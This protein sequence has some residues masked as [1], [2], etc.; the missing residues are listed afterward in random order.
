MSEAASR[1]NSPADGAASIAGV[2]FRVAVA[3]ALVAFAVPLCRRSIVL[4]DEGYMLLQSWD[5]L[6]GK[7][8]YRDMDAFVTPGMWFVLAGTFKLL[9]PSV[10]ASRVPVLIALLAM[11]AASYRITSRLAGPRYGL[12]T[13]TSLAAFTVWAFPAWTFAFYSPFSVTFVLIALE[14]LLAWRAS[15][16]TR[17]L[18]VCGLAAGLAVV[19]K[20][21]YGVFGLM[22]LALGV[23]A[24]R[25]EA[26]LSGRPL[27]R[28]LARDALALAAGVAVAGLPVLV[29]LV[30]EGALP[31]AWHSLVVHPF[32]FS[33]RHDIAYLSLGAIA[34][35]SLMKSGQEM[36]TYG[37]QALYRVP[38]ISTW[39][40]AH[41]VVERMHVLVYWAPP[42]VLALGAALSYRPDSGTG[43]ARER[44]VDAGLFAAVAVA[45]TVFL[46]V[47]PRADFNHLVNVYQP[48]LVA[49]VIV[50]HHLRGRPPGRY[51]RARRIAWGLVAAAGVAYAG[52]AVAWY[53]GL[54]RHLGSK[55]TSERAGVLDR[56]EQAQRLDY[57]IRTIQAETAPGEALLT[58]PDLSMLNF[59]ADRPMPSAFY[60]LYEHHL[61]HD[62][63]AAV[64]EGAK[65]AG[66]RLA[67]V[68]YNDFFSDRVG[69]RTYAPALARHLL[70]DYDMKYTVGREDFIH[71]ERR[72]EPLAEL[73]SLSVLPFCDLAR[74]Y[75]SIR[76]H[77][78]FPALYHDPGTGTGMAAA[79]VETLCVVPVPAEGG[80]FSVRIDYRAP[81]AVVKDTTLTAEILAIGS[82]EKLLLA[83]KVFEVQ[84]EPAG[85]PARRKPL[86]PELQVDLSRWAGGEVRLV[87]RSIRRGRVFVR[88][89]E[90]RGFG[91]VFEDP[92]VLP[93]GDAAPTRAERLP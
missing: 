25:A 31:A 21:N 16:S 2:S 43:A 44:R 39:L 60:N 32:E 81:A 15:L 70:S 74:G 40:Y 34:D 35:A 83:R 38:P 76:E 27:L 47:F 33:G 13:L 65:R 55:V 28:A 51:P 54:I 8:L 64:V 85:T 1:P 93:P 63:G 26:G 90:Q 45:G 24:V 82:R 80:V 66:V 10:I 36:L 52:V 71:L 6:N 88:P 59:L 79:T 92:R 73:R 91:M 30:F 69:L 18:V 17:A 5:L 56:E 23:I 22:G 19:F 29:W 57:Q 42:V 84:G 50:A 41:G 61:A 20:Q 14:R 7:V 11:Y 3:L 67:V 53:A 48:V 4:A 87:L 72:A 75:Q 46:G 89:L 86:A 62:G 49:G 77:L 12:L 9:G 58:V 37:A 78:L 68:R